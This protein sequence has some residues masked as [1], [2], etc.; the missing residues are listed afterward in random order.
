MIVIYIVRHRVDRVVVT[1]INVTVAATVAICIT[2]IVVAAVIVVMITVRA[3][4]VIMP[5]VIVG[6]IGRVSNNATATSS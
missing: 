3:A 6:V 1:S 4:I 2:V 5:M